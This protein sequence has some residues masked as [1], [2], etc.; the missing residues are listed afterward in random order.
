MPTPR[1]LHP[2]PV[3]LRQID[4][5]FTAKYD[6]VLKE[7]IGQARRDQA[8]IKLRAQ[9]HIGTT[10]DPRPSQ[11]GVTETSDG[12]LL[13]LVSDLKAAGVTIDRG[14]RIVQ[15]GEGDGQRETD[16]YIT[17]MQWRGHYPQHR[18]PTMVKCYF[19]DRHPSR[20]RGDL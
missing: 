2:V 7:P 1:L 15:I 20:Q 10:D 18:G 19:E 3:Y 4:R 11:G 16:L 14:D 12:Y 9:V 8:P 6:H 17:R 5:K 13:F